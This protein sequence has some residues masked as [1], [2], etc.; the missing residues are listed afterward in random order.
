MERK[1]V[2]LVEKSY[3]AIPLQIH[4]IKIVCGFFYRL[5]DVVYYFLFR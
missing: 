1:C 2:F 3:I 4:T 5:L